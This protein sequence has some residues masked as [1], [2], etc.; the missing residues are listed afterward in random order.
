MNDDSVSEQDSLLVPESNFCTEIEERLNL[1]W[2]EFY[3]H[4]FSGTAQF[5]GNRLVSCLGY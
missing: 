3:I 2:A 1:F 4:G 5:D